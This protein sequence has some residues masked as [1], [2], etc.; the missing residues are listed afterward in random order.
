[1]DVSKAALVQAYDSSIDECN[2]AYPKRSPPITTKKLQVETDTEVVN[3]EGRAAQDLSSGEA[4]G[5][6]M[7]A[8]IDWLDLVLTNFVGMVTLVKPILYAR[9][10]A[11][12]I[13][14]SVE[15]GDDDVEKFCSSETSMSFVRIKFAHKLVQGATDIT[16]DLEAVGNGRITSESLKFISHRCLWITHLDLSFCGKGSDLGDVGRLGMLENLK[17]LLCK[18]CK[19][20]SGTF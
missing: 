12:T 1:M 16:E 7:K 11:R 19:R 4:W 6:M 8:K 20:L 15:D 17:V 10:E 5:K 9:T 14:F 3:V 13:V 18:R 2:E